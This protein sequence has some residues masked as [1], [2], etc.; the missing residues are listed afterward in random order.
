MGIIIKKKKIVKRITTTF[1]ATLKMTIK[2]EHCCRHPERS[3][4]SVDR[5]FAA[6]K[7]MATVRFFAP[8]KMMV[9]PP[10]NAAVILSE[11]NDLS[12]DF[13]PTAQ[14]D[15]DGEIFRFAQNDGIGRELA[16]TANSGRVG[17]LLPTRFYIPFISK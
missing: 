17:N 10:N 3:E 11:A 4:G 6:L 1:F 16:V 7:M 5:F 2:A 14:N 13:S 8:L 15:G 12:I 9:K